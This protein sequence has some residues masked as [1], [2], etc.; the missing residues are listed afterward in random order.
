MK[1][2]ELITALALD[3]PPVRPAGLSMS[4]LLLAAAVSTALVLSLLGARPDLAQAAREPALWL[5]AAYTGALALAAI[6]LVTRLGRPGMRTGGATWWLLGL[7][8]LAFAAGGVELALAAP[9][10]RPTIWLG[11]SW[12]VC[13]LNILLI[14]AAAAPLIW[15]SARRL[16]PT[17][18]MLSGAAMGATT[19]A[20]AATAYG[21]HCAESTAAFTAIWYSLGIA[22]AAALGALIGR[23]ALRW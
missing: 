1:T 9:D 18:P 12:R 13:S 14:S 23:L 20:V 22:A 17:H 16:A 2:D 19:G 8:G 10:Q 21:L 3:A 6:R 5:K 7:F 11:S 15:L 4:W